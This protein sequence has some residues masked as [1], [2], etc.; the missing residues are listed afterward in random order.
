M[1]KEHRRTTLIARMPEGYPIYAT[2]TIK[3]TGDLSIVG[4]EGQKVNGDCRGSCGQI[5]DGWKNWHPVDGVDLEKFAGI[6]KRWHMNDMRPGTHNQMWRLRQLR[7][8]NSWGYEF[9]CTL[10]EK[11][12]ELVENGYK[13]G[14]AWLREEVPADVL[15]YL[16][17]LQDD[18]HIFPTCWHN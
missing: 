14:S 5:V 6:W 13:Y 18:S 2:V 3:K 10:L 15:E 9:D 7:G 1:K 11:C 17:G 8:E 4:V 16:R 12:G